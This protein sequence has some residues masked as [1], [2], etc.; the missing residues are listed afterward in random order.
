METPRCKAFVIAGTHS[1]CGKTLVSLAVMAA[2]RARGLAV[3]PFKVG[4]DF[5]DPTLHAAVCGR[6]SHNLDPWMCGPEAARGILLRH[7]RGCQAAVVEGVMGLFDGV[8]GASDEGS[9]A[10]LAKLLGLPVALVL[11]ARSKARSAAALALGYTAFDPAVPFAGLILN[12]VGSD[13]HA[14]LLREALETSPN[15]PSSAR[16]LGMLPRDEALA[17]P[18]RHLGLVT[19]QDH[20]LEP[21]LVARLARW[22]EE[23]IDLTRLLGACP[24]LELPPDPA[25]APVPVPRVRIGIARDRAFCFTYA[26][27]LRLLE[28]AGAELV[29]FSP[30]AD[31]ALPPDLHGLYLP[32]GYPELHAAQLAANA[33]LRAAV[34]AFSLSGRPVYAECGGFML[35]MQEIKDAEGRTHP[36][37]GVFAMQAAMTPRF[38]ALGYREAVTTRDS[39]L[40]PAW[41]M[42]R[43]HE[44]HYSSP[45]TADPDAQ[46][47]YRVRD[48]KG[49]T[50]QAEGFQKHNTLGSYIHLHLASNPDAAA[51][52]VEACGKEG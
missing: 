38:A 18:S 39:F 36:M 37:C 32:G 10:A 1:G 6:A 23:N 41:T 24:A 48:R 50:D 47:L 43:G 33:S 34:K 5:I 40:G 49:W 14:A 19:A 46:P 3:A 44:F 20:P 16:I 27:N 13:N 31:P 22:A 17:L 28:A 51:A 8:S 21:E 7:A 12:R 52:F 15:L 30:L 42:L 9:T 45:T 4:P 26:E 25:A 35:L 2:L 29:P 11:D